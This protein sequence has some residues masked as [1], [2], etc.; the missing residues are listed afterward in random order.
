M[1]SHHVELVLELAAKA[2]DGGR[3]E[4]L[5][6]LSEETQR[7]IDSTGRG[8]D[9]VEADLSN[10]DLRRADL[11]RATLSRAV[12]HGTRLQGADLSE[13]TM[14]CPG[15]ER[16]NLSGAI[17]RSAYVHALAAQTCNFDG[18]DMTG[19]RDA[20]GTLF[21]GC[22]ARST[23]LA[24]AHLAGAAFYQ[25]DFTDA[26]F[27]GANLQGALINECLLDDAALIGASLDQL[28]VTKSSLR[29]TSFERVSGRGLVLQRLTAS[30]GLVLAGADLPNLRIDGARG[31]GWKAADLKAVNADF[32]DVVVTGVEMRN[33]E[34]SG[35]RMRNCV[36]PAVDLT[37]TVLN[38]GK[39][40]R[41]SIR[42]AQLVGAQGENLHVVESD[43]SGA[44]LTAFLGRC[45]TARD[46]DMTGVN[47]RQANLYRAM[48]TGDPPKGMSLRRADMENSTLVQ[49]Y[50]AADLREARLTG[51][52]CAYSRFSQSDLSG[53]HLDGVNMYQSTW[54]KVAA[55]G[56]TLAGIRAPIFV[57]RCPGLETAVEETAGETAGEVSGFL[58]TFAAALIVGRKGST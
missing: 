21:H 42:G 35:L 41:S 51:A 34:L 38:D 2:D 26:S 8:L 37:E 27:Q 31:H 30:D 49:A 13:T 43:L 54:I 53:A 16:T 40:S 48:I 46:V 7:I 33:A 57:D 55:H 56:T 23:Q 9:L 4:A 52:N 10:L 28:V 18:A 32:S 44:D 12:L 45:F 25:C 39:V 3:S 22:S 47:L 50:V 36:L 17:L 58:K 29:G 14:V 19:L 5:K 6:Q 20:T 1:I 24:G 11:R 15:M